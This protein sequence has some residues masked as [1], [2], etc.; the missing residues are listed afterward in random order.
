MCVVFV[1]KYVRIGWFWGDCFLFVDLCDVVVG[2]DCCV[3]C[4]LDHLFVDD[5]GG[6]C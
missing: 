4:V 2:E 1:E 6:C 5:V 3:C